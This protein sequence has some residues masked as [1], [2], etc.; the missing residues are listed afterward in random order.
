MGYEDRLIIGA[1]HGGGEEDPCPMYLS[2][3][4]T[5]NLSKM[6]YDNSFSRLVHEAKFAGVFRYGSAR[7]SDEQQTALEVAIEVIAEH[8]PGGALSQDAPWW[9]TIQSMANDK[10]VEAPEHEDAY[11]SPFKRL[12]IS[13]ARGACREVYACEATRRAGM[14]AAMLEYFERAIEQG[15]W[16][17]YDPAIHGMNPN[18][19]I[20]LIHEG[21]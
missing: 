5:L 17:E 11:G 7:F 18:G 4:T 13:E 6:G 14:A 3:I 15:E 10:V 21:Y 12:S 8:A 2:P 19:Q 20:I 16:S 1:V 9:K